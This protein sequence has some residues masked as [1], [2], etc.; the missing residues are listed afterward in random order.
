MTFTTADEVEFIFELTLN[1]SQRK[2]VEHYINTGQRPPAGCDW[3][4]EGYV[5]RL[6]AQM[7]AYDGPT[8]YPAT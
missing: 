1:H 6:T 8:P 7:D 2:M 3:C 4:D 5:R